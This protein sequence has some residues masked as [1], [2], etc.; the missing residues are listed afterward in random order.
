MATTKRHQRALLFLAAA[1]AQQEA[2]H[3]VFF[4]EDDPEV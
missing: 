3:S 1:I 4:D 2:Q